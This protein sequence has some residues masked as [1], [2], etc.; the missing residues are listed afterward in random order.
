MRLLQIYT[1]HSFLDSTLCTMKL[2]VM[3]KLWGLLVGLTVFG[4]AIAVVGWNPFAGNDSGHAN[5]VYLESTARKN[6][7]VK[8]TISIG[9]VKP[10]VGAEVKVGSQIS[11]IVSKLNVSIGQRVEKGDLLA[12]LDESLLLQ[13][14]IMNRQEANSIEHELEFARS[15]FSRRVDSKGV[16]IEQ[17]EQSKKD[18]KVFES[19][20][21]QAQAK[22]RESEIL[23]GYS[24]IVAPVSGT[25]ASISTYEGETVAAS[26]AAP[27]FVNIIDLARQEVQTYVDE[28]DI[29]SVK[30]GQKAMFKLESYSDVEIEG[31][32]NAINP[33]PQIVNDV[34]SYIVLIDF[35]NPEKLNIRPEMTAQVHFILEERDDV[36][37]VPSKSV[38]RESDQFYVVKKVDDDWRKHPVTVGMKESGRME[39]VSGLSDGEVYLSDKKAWLKLIEGNNND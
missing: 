17:V 24:K 23:L 32:V 28:T 3:S 20:L 25:I 36:I 21:K 34:V 39:I 7:F 35:S 13:S 26:L 14:V 29:G 2:R 4:A 19:R 9:T 38:L 33:K 22:T 10:K 6:K 37:V 8:S 18:I 5:L 12:S 27:T 11:G 1:R 30:V 15:Q 16:S 31:V